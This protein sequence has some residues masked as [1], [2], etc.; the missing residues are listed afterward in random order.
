MKKRKPV[1]VE[2]LEAA[3]H[4]STGGLV[5]E[6][7]VDSCVQIMFFDKKAKIAVFINREHEPEEMYDV[8]IDGLQALIES[9]EN[10]F[11]TYQEDEDGNLN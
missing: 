1:N 5:K 3:M 9:L 10:K 11:T 4:E 7:N 8:V 6:F 2:Q